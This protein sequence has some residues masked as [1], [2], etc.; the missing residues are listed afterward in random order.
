MNIII[1]QKLLC[2]KTIDFGDQPGGF[3]VLNVPDQLYMTSDQ[4]W[5]DFNLPFLQ[6]AVARNDIILGT[7]VPTPGGGYGKEV[8]TLE[9]YKFNYNPV[10]H[11][12]MH[13]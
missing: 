9:T 5:T 12:F 6:Q 2:R 8:S 11:R 3:Q 1:N 10:T 4:F 7:T 13:S